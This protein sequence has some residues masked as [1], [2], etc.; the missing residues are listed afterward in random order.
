[1]LEEYAEYYTADDERVKNY[2]STTTTN[3]EHDFVDII[4]DY[5]LR[6]KCVRFDK[7]ISNSEN[8]FKKIDKHIRKIMQRQVAMEV[9]ETYEDTLVSTF[10]A[11]PDSVYISKLPT[12]F[13][14][15]LMHGICQYFDLN[16]KSTLFEFKNE[17]FLIYH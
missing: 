11:S 14:R 17:I 6:E 4:N 13:D 5:C 2:A 10:S 9:L 8:R 1:M 15:L 3:N 7:R 12:S 16:A